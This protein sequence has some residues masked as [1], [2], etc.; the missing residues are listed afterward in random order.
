MKKK[1]TPENIQG[2]VFSMGHTKYLIDHSRKLP[3]PCNYS[4]TGEGWTPTECIQQLE[5]GV[6]KLEEWPLQPSEIINNYAIY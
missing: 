2:I 3:N 5:K 1:Y 4:R 6:W